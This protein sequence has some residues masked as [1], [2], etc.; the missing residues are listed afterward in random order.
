MLRRRITSILLIAL[1]V[2]GNA[3]IA[4]ALCTQF[5]GQ[6]ANSITQSHCR[7]PRTTMAIHMSCC[8]HDLIPHSEK[9]SKRTS[10]CC[11]MSAPLPDQSRPLL[12]GNPS[13]EFK[14]QIQSQLLD[15][16]EPISPTTLTFLPRWVST[17]TFCPDRSDT[18]LLA[19]TFR[20]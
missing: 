20:I 10:G 13:E 18:Y 6:K 7:M 15:S 12:P 5:S 2:G 17:I 19:S 3:G 4:V 11:E 14:L 16:S 8:Q 9:T 1:L